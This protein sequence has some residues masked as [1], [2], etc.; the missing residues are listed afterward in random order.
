MVSK[1]IFEHPRLTLIEDIVVLPSGQEISYLRYKPHRDYPT[2]IPCD[3]KNRFLMLHEYA[4]PIN[5]VL[6]Q[7]PE[8]DSHEGEAVEVAAARE[9]Q[10]E[11]GL[12]AAKLTAIGYSLREHRR[13]TTKNFIVLAEGLSETVPDGGDEE[14]AGTTAVWLTEAEVWSKIAKGEV[15]QKNT[16]TAWAIYQA[17]KRQQTV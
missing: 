9:L 4:Y 1:V 14:E 7:F 3:K 17:Y 8:G 13:S 12:K 10:E 6:L 15:I 16:L 2:I 5:Q 11:A